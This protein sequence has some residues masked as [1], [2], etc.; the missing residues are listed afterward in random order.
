MFGDFS[1]L[2][3]FGIETKDASRIAIAKN[4]EEYKEKYIKWYLKNVLKSQKEY[5]ELKKN[6]EAKI[7]DNSEKLRAY[8]IDGLKKAGK[9][10]SDVDRFLGTNGMAGHYFGRSQWEFPTREV[11]IKLQGFL[12]LP[13]D[14][15]EIYGL[16]ELYES[17][18]SLQ[19]LESMESLQNLQRLQSMERLQR[20]QSMERLQSYKKLFSSSKDYRDVKILPDSVI[21]CDIPY[22]GT[23]EYNA[24]GFNHDEFYS[25]CAKQ[26][27]LV[28]ISS[29]EM[30]KDFI[31]I[32]SFS[33]RSTLCSG[34]GSLKVTEK[35]FIPK[36]QEKLYKSLMNKELKPIWTQLEFDFTF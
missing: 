6:L 30:P 3:E 24:G 9:R 27:E 4:Q 28:L 32:A 19:R 33:H 5:E 25:W 10:A 14:Y 8:L 16:Q 1:L 23:D 34:K 26:K 7:A 35:V 21:Y 31:E 29:Y 22:K 12:Y 36:H 2:A 18:Q 17:L 11:Y 20:L 15:E 13:Q